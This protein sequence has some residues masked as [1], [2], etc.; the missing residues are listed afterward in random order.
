[1]DEMPDLVIEI[2]P[3]HDLVD[4]DHGLDHIRDFLLEFDGFG[5]T[6]GGSLSSL[7]YG[8]PDDWALPPVT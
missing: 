3:I 2:V 7:P 6:H 5:I 8:L 4:F 1:M